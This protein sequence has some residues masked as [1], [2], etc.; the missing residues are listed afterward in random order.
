MLSAGVLTALR[1]QVLGHMLS[2][3]PR[4]RVRE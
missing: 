1:Q 2:A 4:D 3:R